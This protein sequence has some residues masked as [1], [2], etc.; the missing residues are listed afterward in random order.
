MEKVGMST[1]G[2]CYQGVKLYKVC[3]FINGSGKSYFKG[4]PD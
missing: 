2:K 4:D 3:E 1:R